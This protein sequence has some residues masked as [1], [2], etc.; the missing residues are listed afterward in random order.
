MKNKKQKYPVNF[1]QRIIDEMSNGGNITNS[2]SIVCKEFN[3]PFNDT[4]RRSVSH[5]LNKTGVT[6]N[7]KED[8]LESTEEFKIAKEKVFDSSKKRFIISWCQAETKINESLLSNMEAYSK[9]IDASIHIIAGRYKNPTSL[10]TSESIKDKEKNKSLSWDKRV[11]PYLDAN[12][13]NIHPNLCIVSDLKI[14]PTA[15]T[16]LSGLNSLTGIESC[17]I[18]HPRVAL[19]SLPIVDGYPNKL[20]LTTGSVSLENYTDTKSGVKGGFH[21]TYGF[22]VVELDGEEFHIRQVASDIEG[23]F[24]DLNYFVKDSIVQEHQEASAIVFGDLHLGETNSRA[25]EASF[26]LTND[27]GCSDNVILHDVF[28]GH[29]ISHHEKGLP[30]ELL[31]REENGSDSLLN[32]ITEMKEFFK[33]YLDYNFVVVRS[34]HDV[35]LDRWLNTN[36]WRFNN[37]KKA[38]LALASMIVADESGKGVIPVILNKLVENAYGL[39][40]NE[41]YNVKGIECGLHGHQGVNGSRGGILQFKNLNVKTITGHSHSP[42]IEDGAYVV[43][44]LT[45]LRVGYNNGP[46]SWMHANCV[47]YP[48]GKRQLVIINRNNY[49]YTTLN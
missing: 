31:K 5:I 7:S 42:C 39:G 35:F 48:N 9:F 18:G 32:E 29:S 8:E 22:V 3:I 2:C 30:F 23:S 11:I 37:N 24:Y 43:G 12:R 38:Y 14:Q 4:I 20:L 10:S 36:D 21:H 45:E 46:S 25:L 15:S 13:H 47:I 34:N 49:K 41:S 40:I 1:I 44:T 16:P 17:V 6:S 26:K 28:N 33:T 19:K 27:L